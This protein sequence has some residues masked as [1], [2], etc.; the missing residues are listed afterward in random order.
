MGEKPGQGVAGVTH[1]I[2]AEC[3]EKETRAVLA[4]M[5]VQREIE[6]RRERDA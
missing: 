2:C 3:L 6:V 1:G 4:T 5:Q